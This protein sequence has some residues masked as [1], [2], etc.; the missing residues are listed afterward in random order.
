M[1]LLHGVT[2]KWAVMFLMLQAFTSLDALQ[3]A[4][5][6][7]APKQYSLAQSS[8]LNGTGC[9]T[10]FATDSGYFEPCKSN[11]CFIFLDEGPVCVMAA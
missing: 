4:G 7:M 9:L 2:M 8:K 11:L 6:S 10:R 1:E 5:A 3:V